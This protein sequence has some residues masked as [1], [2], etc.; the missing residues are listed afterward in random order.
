MNLVESLVSMDRYNEAKETARQ[1]FDRKLDG[2]YFHLFPYIIAFIEKDPAAMEENLAWFAG[3]DDEYLA[4]ALQ[5]GAA[6]FRGK[7]RAAQDFSRRA[8]DLAGRGNTKEV[9][10]NFAAEQALRI[11]FWSSGTGLP[12]SGDVQLKTV[13]KAQTNKA[14]TLVKGQNVVVAAAL[15]HAAAGHAE[16]ANSL[17]SELA[18]ERPKDSL[19]NH[20]WLPTVRAA[21]MLQ[22]DKAKEALEELEIVERLEKAAEFYPQYLRGLAYLKLNRSREATREFAKILT[23]RGEAPLSSIYP[24]AQL[25]KARAM[26]DKGEYDKFFDLWKDA[27]QDM[28]ALIDARQEAEAL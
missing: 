14:L 25:G 23:H 10:A 1:A 8:I 16:E 17:A 6:G 13:L 18:K 11:V 12:A 26:Q 21:L 22:S 4:L 20:L 3:R 19:L 27:D 7:W 28:P 15:A 9:A 5:A 2:D 24:L